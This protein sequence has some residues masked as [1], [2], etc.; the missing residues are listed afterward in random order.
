MRNQ[1]QRPDA[2]ED[3]SFETCPGKSYANASECVAQVDREA[4]HVA[5]GGACC[6][7]AWGCGEWHGGGADLSRIA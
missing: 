1:H 7:G 2:P 4:A 6:G 3:G 5:S